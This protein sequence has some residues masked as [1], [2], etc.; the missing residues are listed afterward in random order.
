MNIS[1]LLLGID[2]L[3]GILNLDL[4]IQGIASDSRKVKDNYAFVAISGVFRNGNDYIEEAIQNGASVVITD[5][6]GVLLRENLIYV[7]NSRKALA[8]MWNNFYCNP[9]E[10]MKLIAITGTN[11]KS[12]TAQLLYSILKE[13]GEKCALIST[14]KSYIGNDEYDFCGGSEVL[15]VTSSMTTPDPEKLYKFFYNAK[16][17][18][19]K[20]I[21]M[22]ASSH[23]LA[24][25]K[26]SPLSFE[27]GI[28]TNLSSEHMDFHLNMESYFLAK[29]KLFSM[30][31]N[32]IV[33][34]DD[35]YGNLI[36]ARYKGIK[37]FSTKENIKGC[38]FTNNGCK[39]TY[40]EGENEIE[41]ESAVL[42]EFTPQNIALAIMSAQVLGIDKN[43]IKQGV[44]SCECI[45]GRLEKV[46]D[47]IIIDYAHTP[48]AMEKAI[49][50]VKKHF[51]NKN[52][53][54]IFGCGGD[55]DKSK[56]SIMGKIS[57]T[58]ASKVI[59]TADNS[60]SE[61]TTKIIEDI[62]ENIDSD[63]YVII[64]SRK[65]AIKF[66]VERLEENE[67]LLILGKGHENYEIKNNRKIPFS[68]KEIISEALND[69]NK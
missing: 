19:V 43:T 20:M 53:V 5:D 35:E 29:Q 26:L 59:I 60:R 32:S 14:I 69:K 65:E 2:V 27:V 47:N 31:K 51:P 46:Y 4:E 61:D 17:C 37:S 34:C 9:T 52:I 15:D 44:L 25:E 55:R 67:V 39:F 41:I 40:A 24:Q 3:K 11:G 36:K 6:A 16:L 22:E 18:G 49:N 33:N 38:Q 1:Q 68:E 50:S 10:K 62:V 66:G 30:S 63:N 42:G 64:Y 56:R 58:L 48:L 54:V 23:A 21:V 28:F 8:Y 12:S 45:N 13:N 57:T 7:E